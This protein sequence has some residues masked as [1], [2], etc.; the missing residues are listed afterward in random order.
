MAKAMKMVVVVQSGPDSAGARRTL[1][2]CSARSARGE[3]TT[4]ALLG[5]AVRL[6]GAAG[7]EG[8]SAIWLEEDAA[9]RGLTLERLPEAR[10]VAYA[11]LV[12]ALMSATQVIGAL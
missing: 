3:Q 9:M 5:D 1:A 10:A 6:V 2:L 11:E 7:A 4:L 12:D 8:A